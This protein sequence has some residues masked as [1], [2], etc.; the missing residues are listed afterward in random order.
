MQAEALFLSAVASILNTW[1]KTQEKMQALF[2]GK[3]GDGTDGAGNVE[4]SNSLEGG[5]GGGGGG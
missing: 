5:R 2:D 4:F 1:P 3:N